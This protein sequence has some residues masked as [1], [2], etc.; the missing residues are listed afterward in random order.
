MIGSTSFGLSAAALL[1]SAVN[2]SAASADAPVADAM[3]KM[4]RAAVR[5]LLQRKA[6]INAPQVDGMTALH[7]AAYQ[8][9]LESVVRVVRRG[10][11]TEARRLNGDGGHAQAAP[12]PRSRWLQIM[13]SA[14][15]RAALFANAVVLVE[16]PSD[17]AALSIWWPKSQTALRVGSPDDL[18][19]VLLE[20]EG[21][22]GFDTTTKYLDSFAIPWAIVCD[23][24]AIAPTRAN[25]LIRRL[26]STDTADAPPATATFDRWRTWWEARGVY[27]L[28]RASDDEIERF[29]EQHDPKTWEAAKRQER[30]R[31]KPRKAVAFAEA[32]ACP[33]AADWIYAQI[34]SRVRT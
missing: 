18:N 1:L 8:D 32:T 13:R 23:G 20:V 11:Q 25:A 31:S 24:K 5:A 12:L 27:T 17:F 34:I 19:L 26:A 28:A 29:F 9:D 2:L 14:D 4:D 33:A 16:G 6:D 10:G 3:E 21:E 15:M 22:A 30:G 7:W